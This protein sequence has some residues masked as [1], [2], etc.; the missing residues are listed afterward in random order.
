MARSQ[1]MTSVSLNRLRMMPPDRNPLCAFCTQTPIK[2]R[3]AGHVDG[4]NHRRLLGP[5]GNIRPA[6]KE[7]T[8]YETNESAVAA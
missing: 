4:F 2:F 8:D 6:E 3:R 5:I 1:L 7:A